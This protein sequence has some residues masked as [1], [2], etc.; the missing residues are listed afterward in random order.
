[1]TEFL[2]V[3][4][5]PSPVLCNAQVRLRSG[6]SSRVMDHCLE[7]VVFLG[8]EALLTRQEFTTWAATH[9]V[10]WLHVARQR[11]EENEIDDRYWEMVE[12][13]RFGD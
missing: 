6:L 13:G 10:L 1:M 8:S 11:A 5:S 3:P 9:C 7:M 12:E 2:S 4:T